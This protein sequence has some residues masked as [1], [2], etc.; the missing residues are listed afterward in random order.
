V[1]IL[2]KAYSLDTSTCIDVIRPTNL[3]ARQHFELAVVDGHEIVISSIVLNELT[4][5]VGRSKHQQRSS[6]AL[7]FFL[8]GVSV[9]D[10]TA[11]DA[12][13]SGHIRANL[14]DHAMSIGP[15]D[16]LIAGQALRRN[17]IMVTGNV[18]EFSRVKHLVVVN[19]S[20]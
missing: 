20:R 10:F 5:S 19:W 1:S 9:L 16:T 2:T 12:V 15:Y 14:T 11:D 7:N 17:L 6:A 13:S 4:F 18:K 8:G 3:K